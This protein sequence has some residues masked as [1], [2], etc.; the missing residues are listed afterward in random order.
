M[1]R[2]FYLFIVC[3]FS[4][5]VYGQSCTISNGT[6]CLCADGTSN[7]A[8]LPDLSISWYALENNSGGPT[9]YSQSGNGANDGRLRV[10]GLTPNTGYGPFTVRGTDYF[11]CGSD[12]IYDPSRTI[13]T[14]PD[15]SYPKNLLH[16]RIYSK[17]GNAISYID[18]WAGGQTYHPTHG[19]NHV[20][21]WVTFTLRTQDPNEP[22]TLLWPIIGYGAKIGFCLMDLSNC[23]S[24]Y[25]AC[26]D[27]QMLY[28]AGN[29]LAPSLNNIP[30]YGMGG[31]AYNCSPVEQGISV[32]YADIYDE[33]LDGMWITIPPGTCNGDYWI[34]AQVDPLNNF[35]ESNENNNWTAIPFTLTQQTPSGSATATILP[36]GSL[37]LCNNGT[38]ELQA[39]GAN[40]Y[41]WS[42]GATTQNITVSD[43]GKYFVSTTSQCGAAVSDTITVTKIISAV[44]ATQN[45]TTCLNTSAELTASGSGVLNWYDAVSGGTQIGTGSSVYIPSLTADVTYFVENVIT[46]SSPSQRLG[47][48]THQGSSYSGGTTYNGYVQFDAL[49]DFTLQSVTTFTTYPGVRTIELRDNN[50]LVLADTTVNIDTGATVIG[51]NFAVPAGSDYELGTNE[52]QNQSTFGTVTPYLK[53]SDSGVSYP[54]TLSNVAELTGSPFGQDFYYYFYDWV[55]QSGSYTCASP[56]VPVTAHAMGTPNLSIVGLDTAYA[57]TASAVV[58]SGSPAGGTFS[59]DGITIN[60]SNVTFDPSALSPGLHTITYTYADA[61][62]CSG[63]TEMQVRVS[64]VVIDTTTGIMDEVASY[65]R[66]FPNPSNGLINVELANIAK[67]KVSLNLYN[68]LGAKIFTQVVATGTKDT[69][70]LD[71]SAFPTGVYWLEAREDGG[72]VGKTRLIK[73]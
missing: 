15:G 22:D 69:Y 34:V 14:C 70:L 52:A 39:S 28:G 48:V 47:P 29:I 23:Q 73:Q 5:S 54:Y 3:W 62:G 53:R 1:K 44:D 24:S 6:N 46:Q 10:T 57:D 33:G 60:G 13:T 63:Y 38:V 56:R 49:S 25:G 61:F 65:I 67:E 41:L 2:F 21:D 59:G 51:L 17:N 9:E 35:L 16:Q 20:D 43:T 8:L 26:R 11:I 32:G 19:H 42:N 72:I 4:T 68:S 7:C 66:V 37:K 55:V 64:E 30:N 18:R 27:V 12:T 31:G 40:S 58:I 71:L 50:G 45:D 36:L